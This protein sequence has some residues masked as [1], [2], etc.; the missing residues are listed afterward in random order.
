MQH[1]CSS[2]QP[3]PASSA[4][5]EHGVHF[6]RDADCLCDAVAAFLEVGLATGETVL[7]VMAEQ[8]RRRLAPRLRAR[9]I[10]IDAS[11]E[12]GQL[13]VFDAEVALCELMV[14]GAP[15][16]ERFE[17]LVGGLI[18][19]VRAARPRAPVRVYGEMVDVLVQR[20]S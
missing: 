17:R 19:G 6:Y 7:V 20:G 11:V 10:D 3:V 15:H 13:A 2:T 9:G 4:E 1:A 5:R 18:E 14:D 8:N 16:P 12:A